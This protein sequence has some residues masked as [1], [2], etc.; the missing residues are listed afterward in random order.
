MYDEN[1]KSVLSEFR[2]SEWSDPGH[3]N[4]VFSL[5]FLPEDSNL[6]ISGG[7]DTNVHIWDI[8]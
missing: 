5:K 4:R 7:W 3:N 1:E 2:G 6:F 8:R